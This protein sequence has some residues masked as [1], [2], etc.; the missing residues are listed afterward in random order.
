MKNLVS[1]FPQHILHTLWRNNL[2]RGASIHQIVWS[3][4]TWLYGNRNILY[5][6]F[7]NTYHSHRWQDGDLG[8]GTHHPPTHENIWTASHVAIICKMFLNHQRLFSWYC[9]V[10]WMQSCWKIILILCYKL[11]YQKYTSLY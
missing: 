6:Q 10:Y 3:Y 9:W 2:W 8:C 5:V 7:N 4:T 11:H 1:T